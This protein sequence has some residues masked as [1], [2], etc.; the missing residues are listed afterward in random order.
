MP[1][2]R[3]GRLE[4]VQIQD[5]FADESGDF[6][7]WLYKSENLDLL[8]DAINLDLTPSER[9]GAVG[10]LS[11][12]IVAQSELGVV[13]IENQ[14]KQSDHGHL[15]QLL[16]YAAGREARFLVWV[17]PAFK[18]E[19]LDALVW[20]N[21]WMPED[22]EVYRVEVR[23]LKIDDSR[24]APVFRAV[25]SPDT[26]SR[27]TGSQGQMTT[28]ESSLREGFFEELVSEARERNLNVFKKSR[29]T[30]RSKSFPCT[31]GDADLRY[32]VDFADSR[33]VGIMVKLYVSTPKRDH[34]AEIVR[35]LESQ[36]SEIQTELGFEAKYKAPQGRQKAG[37]VYRQ[38]SASIW[39]DDALQ[40]HRDKILDTVSG[41]QRV[42]DPRVAKI[43]QDLE[44]EEADGVD[45][46]LPGD[47]FE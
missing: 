34:S 30:R 44:A 4:E 35:V 19:H 14:I 43:I 6:T 22:L 13:V 42:L 9:E 21:R 32:W 18:Q 2:Q 29:T 5:V 10:S 15:G 7:P 12:D 41:F 37:W 23:L 16:S 40:A 17:A 27:Q 38:W 26:L 24:P 47:D 8:G 11:V 36:A 39:E 25:V 3:L 31:A 46:S 45:A 28:E 20:L 1:T 33:E